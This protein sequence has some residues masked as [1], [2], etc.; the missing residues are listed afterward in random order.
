MIYDLN[1]ERAE[2]V[3]FTEAGTTYEIGRIRPQEL[4]A[5]EALPERATWKDWQPIVRSVLTEWNGRCPELDE[6]T[7][8]AVATLISEKLSKC[9]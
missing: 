3:R 6:R 1:D 8:T 4:A 9:A 7:V 2:T 5:M